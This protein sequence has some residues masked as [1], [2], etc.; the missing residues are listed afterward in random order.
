MKKLNY[1]CVCVCLGATGCNLSI[2]LY[3][4]LLISSFRLVCLAFCWTKLLQWNGSEVFSI[5]FKVTSTVS[6]HN[7]LL[8]D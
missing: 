7:V 8:F 3:I 1:V 2:Y 5:S 6:V 4:Y